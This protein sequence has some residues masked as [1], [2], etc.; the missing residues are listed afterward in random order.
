MRETVPFAVIGGTGFYEIEGM[1]DLE[2]VAVETPFGP[3][4]DIIRVGT[5]G[6]ARVAFL[7]RH[8][9]GHR[10]LPSEIPQQ[11]NMWA[12]AALGVRQLVAVSAV[13][14]LKEEIAPGDMVLPDQL[15]DRTNGQRPSTFFG[16]GVVA[17]VSIAD[18]FC[19]TLNER[20]L[21]A[22]A[23]VTTK[24][25][26]GGT[27]VVIEGPAFSTRAE[28][29]RYRA[30][31]ASVIGM[32][33]SPE[34][35]LAREAGICYANLTCVTDYDTWHTGE[36]SVGVDVVMRNLASAVTSA[37]AVVACLLESDSTAAPECESC[38]A[39]SQ[40]LVTDLGALPHDRRRELSPILER[41]LP[42]IARTDAISAP[43]WKAP[44]SRSA[45]TS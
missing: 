26:R 5:V 22:T 43:K 7:A 31:G 41:Y 36:Q 12:L 18:P 11:A 19:D 2:E 9:A 16:R 3:P 33:A 13:G 1:R 21:Q 40:S 37:R 45:I 23:A 17:H 10:F 35:K 25:H 6:A 14:S 28:S 30:W 39:R 42:R 27:M 8:G 24:V 4:S 38:A 29:L 44:D 20:L 32:T 34:A 15:I